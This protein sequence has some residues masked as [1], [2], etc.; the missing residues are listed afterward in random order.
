MR[1]GDYK[2]LGMAV[3]IFLICTA[4]TWSQQWEISAPVFFALAI[5][6][7]MLMLIYMMNSWRFDSTALIDNTEE[8]HS[9]I[10]PKYDVKF[11]PAQIL[12]EEVGNPGGEKVKR[13]TLLMPSLIFLSKGG[14]D[15]I[16]N[17]PGGKEFGVDVCRP[18]HT[19]KVADGNAIIVHANLHR[20]KPEQLPP[21]AYETLKSM[22][23][24]NRFTPVYFGLTSRMDSSATADILNFESLT[25][26][27]WQFINELEKLIKT[28]KEVEREEKSLTVHPSWGR[29]PQYPSQGGGQGGY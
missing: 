15:S 3:L 29:P 13:N 2:I 25:K 24:F 21:P 26:S 18:E 1:R 6:P 23:N 12:E 11:L 16:I 27:A 7:S 5:F 28:K 22:K 14:I 20:I 17:I 10:C 8:G 4:L 9:S 19:E